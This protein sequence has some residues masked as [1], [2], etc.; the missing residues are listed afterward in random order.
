[1]CIGL[2][3]HGFICICSTNEGVKY[4]TDVDV[5][6]A[7]WIS[8]KAERRK[9]LPLKTHFYGNMRTRAKLSGEINIS[10]SLWLLYMSEICSHTNINSFFTGNNLTK[11]QAVCP[12]GAVIQWCFLGTLNKVVHLIKSKLLTIFRHDLIVI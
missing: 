1:M 8:M 5:K 7:T 11:S 3:L 10:N 6:S 4:E 12:I 9:S 2:C